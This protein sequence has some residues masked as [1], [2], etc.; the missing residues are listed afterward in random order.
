M[1]PQ[2]TSFNSKANGT[3]TLPHQQ[4][5]SVAGLA[6]WQLEALQKLTAARPVVVTDDDWMSRK[7]YRALLAGACGLGVVD[8]WDP[9]EA[10]RL[11]S[12]Q[13]VSLLISCIMKPVHKD[14][15]TLASE[16]RANPRTANVPLLIITATMNTREMALQ[17]GADAYLNKPCHPSEILRTIWQLLRSYAL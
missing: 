6:G 11:C 12:A 10:L 8:T 14:G 7:Y 2:S 4:T 5:R 9:E 13:P 15:L 16:L 3:G 1:P 17:A